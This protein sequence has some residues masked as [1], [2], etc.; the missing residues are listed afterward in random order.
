MVEYCQSEFKSNSS[1]QLIQNGSANDSCNYNYNIVST[2]VDI[3]KATTM[4]F[5]TQKI[6]E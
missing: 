6:T 4:L 1:M 3:L 5:M 2:I